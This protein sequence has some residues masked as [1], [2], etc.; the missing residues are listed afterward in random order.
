M[1]NNRPILKVAELCQTLPCLPE[2]FIVDFA[3]GIDVTRDHLR[4]LEAGNRS[5]FSRLWNGFTGESARRQVEIDKNLAGDVEASL[6]WL[7]ELTGS[8]AK[9]NLAITHVNDRLN[10]LMGDTARLAHYSADT[11]R[12]L[13]T[14][15]ARIETRLD[16]LEKEYARLNQGRLAQA[17]IGQ[18]FS[19]WEAG[20]YQRFSQAGRCYAALENLYWGEFGDYY[21]SVPVEDKL[22]QN[23]LETVANRAAACLQKDAK[24]EDGLPSLD[25]LCLPEARDGDAQAALSYLGEGEEMPFI[26]TI[27]QNPDKADWPMDFPRLMAASRLA[28]AL[29]DEIFGRSHNA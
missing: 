7:T 23:L 27:S 2:K 16:A 18:V 13:E 5:F 22:R 1:N 26:Q 28:D 17:Q 29:V 20:R 10:S 25:W 11:R 3:N 8:L 12:M 21:R 15:V 6:E 4:V 24:T 19:A 14:C 9:S